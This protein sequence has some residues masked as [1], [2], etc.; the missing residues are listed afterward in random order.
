[1]SAALGVADYISS[2]GQ[3]CSEVEGRPG[4]RVRLVGTPGGVLAPLSGG[5]P[6]HLIPC[7]PRLCEAFSCAP[8]LSLSPWL[9]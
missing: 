7:D 5:T 6:P 4:S 3:Q 1:M 9:S 8:V 2:V